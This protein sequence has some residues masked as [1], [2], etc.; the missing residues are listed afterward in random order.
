MTDVHVTEVADGIY[1]MKTYLPEMDFTVN[2]YL[3]AGEEPLL[4]HTGTRD[5]FPTVVDA[6][7]RVVPVE[8]LRWIG[9]GHV[10]ADECG[11]LAEWLDAAPDATVIQ[12]EIG[13]MVTLGAVG[14]REP[15]PLAAGETLDT[16]GHCLEWI[17][18]PH[19]PHGWDAGVLYDRTT[20]TLFCGDLFGCYGDYE[21]TTSADVVGPAIEAEDRF[22]AMSLHPATPSL[23]GGLAELDLAALASMHGPTFT[24][25]C[26]AAL[27]DL[28]VDADRR[29]G[30]L[31]GG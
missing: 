30:A 16:G 22:P 21:P 26:G 13:C 10:E 5:M 12:G 6:V 24:G 17:D 7:A 23:I 25:D 20:K 29:I 2:Q 1:Q 4:F 11:C 18:T 19:V 15:R 3:V 28:A 8:S 27:R 9:F 31:R 14:D